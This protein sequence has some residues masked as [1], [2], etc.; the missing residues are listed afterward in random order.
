MQSVI[1]EGPSRSTLRVIAEGIHNITGMEI[2]ELDEFFYK[3]EEIEDLLEA[4][5]SVK[6]TASYGALPS[7]NLQA[8]LDALR[9]PE[10]FIFV[11][12]FAEYYWKE[13]LWKS[14]RF[15]HEGPLFDSRIYENIVKNSYSVCVLES[16]VSLEEEAK[17]RMPQ[18]NS[19]FSRKGNN[20][21][22]A[23]S[24]LL[25]GRNAFNQY[26][27]FDKIVT[28]P[29]TD[30]DESEGYIEETGR[31][32]GFSLQRPMRNSERRYAK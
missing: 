1:L 7:D 9:K 22:R 20:Y 13:E 26:E 4:N 18:A 31:V 10:P 19:L 3:D 27:I 6:G 16:E 14:D 29:N 23:L 5:H 30:L 17:K 24:S 15:A 11:G 12:F 25:K 28:R 2:I 32:I 8:F 21:F